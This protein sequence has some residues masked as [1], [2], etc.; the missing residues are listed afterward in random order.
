L[1]NAAQVAREITC[2]P[3]REFCRF[4]G[5][6]KVPQKMPGA[7]HTP[8]QSLEMFDPPSMYLSEYYPKLVVLLDLTTRLSPITSHFILLQGPIL[9]TNILALDRWRDRRIMR[10]TTGRMDGKD[11]HCKRTKPIILYK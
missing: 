6:H 2:T 8:K 10:W 3:K 11:D 1:C 7:N 9:Y 5:I 4:H